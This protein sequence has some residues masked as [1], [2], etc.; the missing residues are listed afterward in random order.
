[1]LC[2]KNIFP[3]SP[4]GAESAK[5][6]ALPVKKALILFKDFNNLRNSALKPTGDFVKTFFRASLLFFLCLAGC[7]GKGTGI[8]VQFDSTKPLDHNQL[9]RHCDLEDSSACFLLGKKPSEPLA[10]VPVMQGV[11][12]AGRAIFAIL[13]RPEQKLTWYLREKGSLKLEPLPTYQN[14][15]RPHSAFRVEQVQASGL[16][17]G[18][19]Y[20]LLGVSPLGQLVDQ[21]SFQTLSPTGS[22]RF[23]LISGTDDHAAQADLWAD[24]Y[25]QKPELILSLGN[26]VYANSRG[27][28]DL[29]E[30]ASAEQLWERYSE[31]RA[32]LPIFM[33]ERLI[34]FL[35]TWN[36]QDYGMEDGDKTYALADSSRIT[37]EAFFPQLIDAKTV[38]EGPG[39]SRGLKIAGQSF[40]LF[41]NRSFRT[42]AKADEPAY[43][44]R[45]QEDWA[46]SQIGNHGG[47][48]MWLMSG[49]K[50]FGK[51]SE[52][53]EKAR[54][55]P[56][57]NFLAKLAQLKKKK[58]YPIVFAS[59]AQSRTEIRKIP[60]F[61]TFEL[62]SGF[63]SPAVAIKE[64][65]SQ[66][67]AA[68]GG[69]Y[70]IL[71][72]K[73]GTVKAQIRG[74]T[75]ILAEKSIELKAKR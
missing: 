40:L 71:E 18:K 58:P 16:A 64:K 41:D 44:G 67:L 38:I 31:T 56:F 54:P 60:S 12:P 73:G 70:M 45:I 15:S 19:T 37:L 24:L 26:N 66:S 39:V 69:G 51:K 49:E 72:A 5:I 65:D 20:E 47:G 35:V 50:W 6:L 42:P 1:M 10:R 23:A 68:V 7:A 28:M 17:A 57:V 4:A 21:R 61:S 34:P 75:G 46:L 11:A 55:G 27:A 62:S 22:L 59:G 3:Y 53:F 74:A 29:G 25:E 13:L 32:R 9:E 33:Q 52:S 48:P 2:V 14:I 63:Q 8:L 30:S 43:F 36:E